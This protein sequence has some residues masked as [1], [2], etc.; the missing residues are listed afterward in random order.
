[1]NNGK[2]SGRPHFARTLVAM[3]YAES[4]QDAFDRYL[5]TPEYYAIE[6]PKPAPEEGIAMIRR[7]GGVA[8][9]AHPYLLKL[10]DAAFRA[11]LELL[12]S[13]G[14]QGIECY[15]S[16]H[17][18]EETAYYKSIAEEYSLLYTCGSDYHGVSVKPDIQLGSGCNNSLLKA[19]VPEESLLHQLDAAMAERKRDR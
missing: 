6:R 14:L 9:L 1:M 3:G 16:K 5:T 12:I 10:E 18:P 17:T 8:V 15:Y 11:L 19:G 7:A 13:Y 4:V 2:S